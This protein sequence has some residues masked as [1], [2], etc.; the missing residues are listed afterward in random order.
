M[1]KL[2]ILAKILNKKENEALKI[3]IKHRCTLLKYFIFFSSHSTMSLSSTRSGIL[4][5]KKISS[6]LLNQLFIFFLFPL[7]EAKS[8]YFDL[9]SLQ[10]NHFE[11]SNLILQ[12]AA[13]L[14]PEGLQLTKDSV[15]SPLNYSVG[16]ALYYERVHLRDKSTGWR[17]DFTTHF[18]FII[19]GVDDHVSA[20]GLAF[21]IAPFGS[22]MLNNSAGG[23]LGLFSNESALNATE[24]R[25]IAVEFDTYQNGWDP[26]ANHVGID[27]NSIVS[28]ATVT[29]DSV[30]T[31]GSTANG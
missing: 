18:S 22:D 26:I 25:I 14:D 2:K 6:L 13:Y 20:D 19:A 5:T 27:V 1:A 31:H 11:T 23:F 29:W 10:Q 30:F 7:P 9:S 3:E 12:G 8:I 15:N 24:N 21:F 28:N 17:T 4:Q 16:R